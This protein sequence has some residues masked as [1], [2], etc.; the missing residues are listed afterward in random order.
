MT[1]NDKT[2]KRFGAKKEFKQF[3]KG[4]IAFGIYHL[5]KFK[6]DVLWATKFE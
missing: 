3:T 6:F 2:L 4:I 5:G 1:F